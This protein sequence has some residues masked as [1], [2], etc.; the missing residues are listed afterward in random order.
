VNAGTNG[1]DFEWKLD[2]KFSVDL[3]K[4]INVALELRGLR[5]H[6]EMPEEQ[7]QKLVDLLAQ[8]VIQ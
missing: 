1:F 3:E 2:L 4:M 8:M 6:E 5:F 7:K